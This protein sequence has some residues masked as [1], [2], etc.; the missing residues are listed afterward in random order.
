LIQQARQDHPVVWT[1]PVDFLL[2]F[3]I[4]AYPMF[5]YW[6][7]LLK[8]FTAFTFWDLAWSGRKLK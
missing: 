2:Y 4:P 8:I 6:H 3:V 1:Y 7:S 5:A